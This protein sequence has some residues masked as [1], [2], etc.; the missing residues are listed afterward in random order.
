MRPIPTS[1][2]IGPLQIH[3]YGIGLALT[4]WFA[5]RYFERRLSKRGFETEWVASLFIWVIASAI[6]GA[7]AMHVLSNLGYYSSHPSQIFA[8]WQGGLSSFG[9]LLLAVPTAIL[10]A[11]RRCPQLGVLEGLDIVA[12]VLMAAW[13]I[14]RLLGPQ[15][16]V[17][18]GGHATNQ[19][20]GMYYDGQVGKRLPVPLFQ[21]AEDFTVYIVL[22]LIERRLNQRAGDSQQSDKPSGLV[23]SVAMILWGIERTLDER[24]WLGQDGALGS[25]L[26]QLAGV[27]LVIGGVILFVVS[28]RKWKRWAPLDTAT[29]SV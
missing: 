29:P 27:L 13:A 22:I 19:W 18:G 21:A 28:V 8:I 9:G 1:F 5:Y 12:P 4:F 7:R 16:M 26:V 11:R 14:G 20:F 23:T 15:M 17:A 3:T 24:L 2:H 6:V 10:I 25:Q